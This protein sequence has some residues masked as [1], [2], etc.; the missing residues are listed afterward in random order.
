LA[1][2]QQN[3][4]ADPLLLRSARLEPTERTPVW[5]MRQAGRSLP[6]Y[7]AIR[8]KHDL[9][10][11]CRNPELCAEVSLLPVRRLGVDAAVLFADIMLP[12]AFGMGVS[13]RLVDD[14]GPVIDQPIRDLGA[15]ERLSSLSSEEAVPFVLDTIRLVR[16]ALPARVAL[17]GFSGAPFTLA[18]YLIEGRPSRDFVHTKALMYGDPQ[19]WHRLME[20]LS[21]MVIDYLRSQVRA[22]AEVLQL[23]DSWVGCLAP[24]DYRRYVMPHVRP[25]FESGLATPMIHFATGATHLLPLLREAGGDLIGLDWRVHLGEAWGQVGFDRGVQGNLDPAAMLAPWSVIE[26]KARAVLDAAGGR[27]GH[28][29]N[30]GHGVLP[31]TPVE[32]LQRL[33]ELVHS[34][35][36]AKARNR[37][38]SAAGVVR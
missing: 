5:F 16:R 20:R 12:I 35:S 15:V 26:E 25:I 22:G 36:E 13:L 10:S 7:Q 3:K 27:P 31:Q 24:E 18:G 37:L 32:P 28:I 14:V 11:I 30:L 2:S 9:F 33:T 34:L 1:I 38:A 6:E 23:F 8:E 21:A 4:T 17:V 19:L 29:F